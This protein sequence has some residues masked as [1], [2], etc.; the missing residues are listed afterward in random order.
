MKML[1]DQLVAQL[2]KMQSKI[3]KSDK[4]ID[5]DRF[6]D[7]FEYADGIFTVKPDILEACETIAKNVASFSS[8]EKNVTA[9]LNA[10]FGDEIWVPK[11]ASTQFDENNDP[12]LIACVKRI[13]GD[14]Q[15]IDAT[16][17]KGVG[18]AAPLILQ[19][20]MS[21][22]KAIEAT[23]YGRKS[24]ETNRNQ[25]TTTAVHIIDIL[26]LVLFSSLIRRSDTQMTR[27]AMEIIVFVRGLCLFLYGV[28]ENDGIS[29]RMGS[30]LESFTQIFVSYGWWTI[31]KRSSRTASLNY[32]FIRQLVTLTPIT[33][34]FL[35]FRSAEPSLDLVG[36][37]LL[38]N[39][40]YDLTNKVPGL[41]YA[42]STAE[43]IAKAFVAIYLVV[44]GAASFHDHLGI[45]YPDMA[46]YIASLS[47]RL[48]RFALENMF[49]TTKNMVVIAPTWI[50]ALMYLITFLYQNCMY[51]IGACVAYFGMP[52]MNMRNT[53]YVTIP[54]VVGGGTVF[55][56]EVVYGA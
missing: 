26:L 3:S 6:G 55:L 34:R 42:V 40:I 12:Q 22:A 45:S 18:V 44:L 29:N 27:Y 31:V 13:H 56:L 14:L 1:P 52:Y 10:M 41:N 33:T 19:K 23:T 51:I 4:K 43:L 17:E 32:R 7:F 50:P 9:F 11:D 8:L 20:P 39:S 5:G 38:M 24:S 30:Q 54:I 21:R 35:A 2:K 46:W 15:D 47:V 53:R 48:T 16:F 25:F 37:G 49:T 36:I 28:D